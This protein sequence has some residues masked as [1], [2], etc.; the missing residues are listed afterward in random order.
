MRLD[1]T[2]ESSLH[3]ANAEKFACAAASA[4]FAIVG[5][6]WAWIEA[7]ERRTDPLLAALEPVAVVRV[8]PDRVGVLRAPDIDE[9]LVP[10]SLGWVELRIVPILLVLR[11]ALQGQYP[12]RLRASARRDATQHD[13]PDHVLDEIATEGRLTGVLFQLGFA[14]RMSLSVGATLKSPA[15]MTGFLASSSRRYF[16]KAVFHS[17]L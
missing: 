15:Q 16:S 6:R 9:R 10:A 17:F 11:V 7:R 12:S 14:C 5:D 13:R 8:L 4:H 3:P 2:N 1:R